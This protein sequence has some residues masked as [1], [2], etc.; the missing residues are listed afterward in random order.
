MR[1]AKIESGVVVAVWE[2]PSLDCYGDECLLV[3]APDWVGVGAAFDGSTFTAPASPPAAPIEQVTMRQA[4]LAMLQAGL[5][6]AVNAAVAAADEATRIEW[7]F[8][9]WVERD[10]ALVSTL[11]SALGLTDQQLDDL[12]ALA[13]TL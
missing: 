3:Q 1:A 2:V 4:R 10:N 7:E 12:F 6:S 8:S 5:L 9:N 11:A 13:A